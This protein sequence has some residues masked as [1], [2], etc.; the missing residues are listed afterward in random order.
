MT[1]MTTPSGPSA[2]IHHWMCCKT[3]WIRRAREGFISLPSQLAA[4]TSISDVVIQAFLFFL[5]ILALVPTMARL[6][7]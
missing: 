1:P 3:F 4:N 5:M 2:L 6:N 7:V